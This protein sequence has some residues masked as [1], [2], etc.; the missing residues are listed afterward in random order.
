MTCKASYEDIR[1]QFK[2]LMTAEGYMEFA[3]NMPLE[4]RIIYE[5]SG[6]TYA[7]S[8]ALKDIR[9]S[10]I[11]VANPK[12]LTWRTKSKKKNHK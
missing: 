2:F 10:D 3:R 7:V 11:T 1:E 12:E 4:T 9:Y 5:A 8:C 6:S